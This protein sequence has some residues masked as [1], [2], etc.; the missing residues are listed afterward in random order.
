MHDAVAACGACSLNVT[1]P[2]ENDNLTGASATL[3]A[4]YD[5]RGFVHVLHLQPPQQAEAARRGQKRE[6]RAAKAPGADDDRRC[7]L[8]AADACVLSLKPLFAATWA[9]LLASMKVLKGR[10]TRQAARGRQ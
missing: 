10:L 1:A 7:A 8:H 3:P 5:W 6:E 4:L 2:A 9:A